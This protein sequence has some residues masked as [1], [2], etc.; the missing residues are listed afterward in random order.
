MTPE[1]NKKMQEEKALHGE[2]LENAVVRGQFNMDNLQRP[3]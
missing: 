2:V 3:S 1:E